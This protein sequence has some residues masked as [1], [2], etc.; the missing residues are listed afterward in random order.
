MQISIVSHRDPEP[1]EVAAFE[2]LAAFVLDREDAPEAIELSIAIVEVEE[3]AQ[4]NFDYRGKE[5]PTDVLSFECDDPC[6]VVGPDESVTLGDVVIAPAIAES[7]AAEYGH[8]VEEELNLLLVHGILHLL[9][10]DHIE[11][12]DAQVM[13]ARERVLLEAWVAAS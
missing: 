11:D 7:Q 6:A 4:L 12:V 1:L 9:G 10:Y 5:G 2:R 3:M 8:T 13:Q